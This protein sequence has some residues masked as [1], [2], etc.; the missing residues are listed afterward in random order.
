MTPPSTPPPV[1]EAA[2]LEASPAAEEAIPAA[3]EASLAAEVDETGASPA[4]EEAAGPAEDAP[5]TDGG[6]AAPVAE[7][8]G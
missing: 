1:V 7:D 4:A 2:A 6:T 8:T 3:E 5:V